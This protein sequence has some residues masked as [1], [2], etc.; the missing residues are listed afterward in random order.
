M[1][2]Y[3]APILLQIQNCT[4]TVW[5]IYSSTMYHSFAVPPL[6]PSCFT[7]H[8]LLFSF[9]VWLNFFFFFAAL[10][11]L[12][13]IWF[14]PAWLPSFLDLLKVSLPPRELLLLLQINMPLEEIILNNCQSTE[15]SFVNNLF[16]VIRIP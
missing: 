11:V 5:F 7:S 15:S 12:S 6:S 2:L 10:Y 14:L 8:T 4:L 13:Y 9:I 16:H 1:Q 3:S